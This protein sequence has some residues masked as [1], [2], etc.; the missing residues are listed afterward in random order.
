MIQGP[1]SIETTHHLSPDYLLQTINSELSV[2][3]ELLVTRVKVTEALVHT[4]VHVN[5]LSFWCKDLFMCKD[6]HHHHQAG[7]KKSVM[8][9]RSP[10][11][12]AS[13]SMP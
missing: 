10:S 2:C 13:M 11:F 6:H 5:I 8:Q 3:K 9:K 7:V 12:S 1:S 4:F